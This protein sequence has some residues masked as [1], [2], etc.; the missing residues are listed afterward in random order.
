MDDRCLEVN[1][2][3][4]PWQRNTQTHRNPHITKSSIGNLI[5]HGFWELFHRCCLRWSPHFEQ[6][7]SI[8]GG[9]VTGCSVPGSSS[10]QISQV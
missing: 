7:L 5:I 8:K 9:F 2:V 10:N 4:V 3:L 1:M 6:L